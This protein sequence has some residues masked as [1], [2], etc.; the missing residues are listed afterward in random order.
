MVKELIATL[1]LG[2]RFVSCI[3]GNNVTK[4]EPIVLARPVDI[5][6]I[7]ECLSFQIFLETCR[8]FGFV[9]TPY[10]LIFNFSVFCTAIVEARAAELLTNI[11]GNLLVLPN[12]ETRQI[13]VEQLMRK[14]IVCW[15][16]KQGLDEFESS[17]EQ[18]MR[19]M[20]RR[21]PVHHGALSMKP[22]VPPVSRVTGDSTGQSLENSAFSAD[23]KLKKLCLYRVQYI[24]SIEK[25][26]RKD[27]PERDIPQNTFPAG[28]MYT[29]SFSKMT[30]PIIFRAAANLNSDCLGVAYPE[31]LP[32]T[33]VNHSVAACFA[34]G[35][36]F[37]AMSKNAIGP[38]R[39][40][41][42]A[43]FAN[44]GCSGFVEKPKNLT[45]AVSRFIKNQSTIQMTVS[46]AILEA[47]QLPRGDQPSPCSSSARLNPYVVV[48]IRGIPIDNHTEIT[49]TVM[50]NGYNPRWSDSEMKFE[51][52]E[53]T[54][55]FLIF[56]VMHEATSGAVYLAGTAYRAETIRHG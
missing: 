38:A 45:S 30:D 51:V 26:Q 4:T 22:P 7:P 48:S 13:P 27:N 37:C 14:I 46:V 53:P 2:V 47:F 9:A 15:S 34:L 56:E 19:L 52:F 29:C 10:P 32:R 54:A 6:G 21:E 12:Q 17:I 24:D 5:I 55:A 23:S 8:D 18:Y 31:G 44:T 41:Q 16:G 43:V 1:N 28:C 35:F 11:L 49:S 3:L 42:Q 50:N 39:H 20:S 33:E 36:Q 25:I 40:I